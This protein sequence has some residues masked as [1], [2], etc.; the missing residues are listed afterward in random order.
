[1]STSDISVAIVTARR[2]EHTSYAQWA[3]FVRQFLLGERVDPVMNGEWG[4]LMAALRV[5]L[6]SV[7]HVDIQ[8]AALNMQTLL[9]N[10]I[11][12]V[13][14]DGEYGD[15]VTYGMCPI[16]W[17]PAA[18]PG[19]APVGNADKNQAINACATRHMIMLDD[20]C[21][22]S[23]GFVELAKR[24]CDEGNILL[25]EHWKIHLPVPASGNTICAVSKANVYGSELGRRVFGIWAMPVCY[26]R[27]SGGY[28]ESLDGKHGLWDEEYL[29][30]MDKYVKNHGIEYVRH[31]RARVYEIEHTRPWEDAGTHDSRFLETRRAGQEENPAQEAG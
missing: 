20:C 1:M 13:H 28:D 31:P 27:E 4:A 17:M 21:I 25:P 6:D 29:E 3:P 19:P 14:R 18:H 23:F 8:I 10:G 15:E 2:D 22:P 5:G 24:V 12:V 9:P 26:A 7:S 16:Q 30:R 11:N